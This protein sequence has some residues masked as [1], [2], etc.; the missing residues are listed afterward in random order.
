M[1]IADILSMP[2]W[3]PL[4]LET[5]SSRSSSQIPLNSFLS[6]LAFTQSTIYEFVLIYHIP[7]HPI[8]IKSM[9]SFLIFMMS[10]L[11][12]IICSSADRLSFFLYYP[13]PRARERFRPPLTLPKV[14]VPPAF[15]I[16]LISSG[17]YGLWS[18]LSS[19]VRPLTQATA[20]ESPALAQ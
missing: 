18:L 10:G 14:T 4:S 12:V 6:I 19:W 11:A 9:F 15:V 17:S 5:S 20:L 8:I 16:L 1:R 3:L 7:S 13:S 2:Y